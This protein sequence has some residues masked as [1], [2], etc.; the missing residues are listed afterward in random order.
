MKSNVVERKRQ[1]K[2]NQ[3]KKTNGNAIRCVLSTSIGSAPLKRNC[4]EKRAREREKERCEMCCFF[5]LS[6]YFKYEHRNTIS[7]YIDIVWKIVEFLNRSISMGLNKIEI[8]N[9]CN[10]HK[11][12]TRRKKKT[13]TTAN[14]KLD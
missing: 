9:S 12:N 6:Q 8:G 1:Q 5:S 3:I 7:T 11:P 13:T 4:Y 14:R 10:W 2:K